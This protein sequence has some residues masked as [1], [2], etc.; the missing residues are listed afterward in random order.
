V[1]VPSLLHIYMHP[2]M[3]DLSDID[4][5]VAT[6]EDPNRRLNREIAE[7]IGTVDL[8]IDGTNITEAF[9]GDTRPIL[10]V[11]ANADGIVPPATAMYPREISGSTTRDV[12]WVGTD[13][14]R[15]AHADLYLADTTQLDFFAPLGEWLLKLPS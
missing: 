11:V 9:S 10:C 12:L 3:V 14:K 15:Y 6:V 5:V 2:E 7:W 13:K 1:R 8:T 4:A